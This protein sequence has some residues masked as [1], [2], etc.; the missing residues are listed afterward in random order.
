MPL[1]VRFGET[2]AKKYGKNPLKWCKNDIFFATHLPE[3]VGIFIPHMGWSKN[4]CCATAWLKQPAIDAGGL[5]Y[6]EFQ[7]F[8]RF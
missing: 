1:F 4:F 5:L 3:S 7:G 6:Y 8:N 2:L